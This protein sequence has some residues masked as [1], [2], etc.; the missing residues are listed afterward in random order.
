MPA[1]VLLL[2][3]GQSTPEDAA[4]RLAL[5]QL[6]VP[7]TNSCNCPQTGVCVCD[8][9]R[10]ACPNCPSEHRNPAPPPPKYVRY[11]PYVPRPAA[12]RVLTQ[13]YSTPTTYCVGGTCYRR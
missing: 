4:L 1:L 8:A 11:V 2:A 13:A 10:C 9:G 12:Y 5:A 3:L 6:S 7:V